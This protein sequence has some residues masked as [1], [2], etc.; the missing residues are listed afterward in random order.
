[1]AAAFSPHFCALV[2]S[3]PPPP[4]PALPCLLNCYSHPTGLPATQTVNS[5][6]LCHATISIP[7]FCFGRLQTFRLTARFVCGTFVWVSQEEKR[8]EVRTWVLDISVDRKVEQILTKDARGCY[9]GSLLDS[10][11]KQYEPC[12]VTGF[13]ILANPVKY[14]NR[15]ANKEDWNKFLMTSKTANDPNLQDV[16]SFMAKWCGAPENASYSF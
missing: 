3:P 11:G 13:P 16:M 4:C 1:M 6:D 12:I 15:T 8:E 7:L 14:G 10:A 9:A 5:V 2:L